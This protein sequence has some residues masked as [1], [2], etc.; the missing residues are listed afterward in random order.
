LITLEPIGEVSY[1]QLV[2]MLAPYLGKIDPDLIIVGNQL[3]LSP[4][5]PPF[6]L[7]LNRKEKRIGT[8]EIL[9]S[10]EAFPGQILAHASWV[11]QNS[12]IIANLNKNEFHPE[13]SPFVIGLT[14]SYPGWQNL[15]SYIKLDIRLLKYSAMSCQGAPVMIFEPLFQPVISEIKNEIP[16][17]SVERVEMIKEPVQT[18]EIGEEFPPLPPEPAKKEKIPSASPVFH[19]EGFYEAGVSGLTEEEVRYFSN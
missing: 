13:S 11:K 10:K 15:L 14:S 5:D 3:Q 9:N 2:D 18:M 19:F 12:Y 17:P 16:S 4:V 7:V 8:I 1:S 6:L